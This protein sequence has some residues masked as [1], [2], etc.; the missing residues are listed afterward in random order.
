MTNNVL[1]H[2]VREYP[3]TRFNPDLISN[4]SECVS[5]L[6]FYLFLFWTIM[7]VWEKIFY[8]LN[9]QDWFIKNNVSKPNV[10]AFGQWIDFFKNLFFQ[11]MQIL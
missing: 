9:I 3:V 4:A 10:L 5:L 7:C 1:I 11:S 8:W 2:S 6:S